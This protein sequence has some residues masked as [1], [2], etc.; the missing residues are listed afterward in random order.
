MNENEK[1]L[2]PVEDGSR[3][4][5]REIA[6]FI[7]VLTMAV[8]LFGL[9]SHISV[10]HGDGS[11]KGVGSG[12]GTGVGTGRGGGAGSGVG[13]GAGMNETQGTGG[14]KAAS[15]VEKEV[16]A[17]R[18]GKKA[19][20]THTEAPTTSKEKP[21][22]N[23]GN[24]K[25]DKPPELK[26]DPTAIKMARKATPSRKTVRKVLAVKKAGSG[27]GGGGGK[28]KPMGTGDISFRIYWTPKMHDVDLHVIDP[29]G[30]HLYFEH[31]ECACAGQ[32]DVD[33]T[34]HGGPENIFWPTGK[35][36]KGKFDYFV[37]YYQGVGRKHVKIEVRKAGRLVLT[38][39]VTLRKEGDESRHFSITLH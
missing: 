35:S 14:E 34:T 4:P 13:D 2:L 23:S 17:E 6:A 22:G 9:F 37:R 26:W 32:L 20:P 21:T 19:A 12:T 38:K 16:S 27:S 15:K 8:L 18:S 30:H 24:K 25:S 33:D 7:A 11:G 36:P 29:N 28:G 1:D 5:S 3:R 39:M 10:G 31:K